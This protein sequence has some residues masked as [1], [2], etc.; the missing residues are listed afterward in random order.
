MSSMFSEE[1]NQRFFSMLKLAPD[2]QKYWDEQEQMMKH[3]SV[4][5]A[6]HRMDE[7]ESVLLR[8]F[9]SV[10]IGNSD[11]ANFDFIKHVKSMDE[12]ARKI[13]RKWLLDPFFC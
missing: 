4:Q 2:L 11:F 5:I 13:I 9:V 8:F 12:T 7:E 10:W 6:L 1:N 3:K